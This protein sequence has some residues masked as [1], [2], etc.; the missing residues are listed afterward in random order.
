[1]FGSTLVSEPVYEFR[2]RR[3]IPGSLV[4]NNFVPDLGRGIIDFKDYTYQPGGR[5]IYN[6]P[7]LFLK[8]SEV[9]RIVE[10]IKRL[11]SF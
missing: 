11:P 4:N 10:Q 6:L 2:S 1:L 9:K 5:R 7:G 3:L 8:E